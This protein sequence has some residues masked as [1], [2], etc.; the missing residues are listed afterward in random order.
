MYHQCCNNLF[1]IR[2]SER[3]FVTS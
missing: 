2:C 3:T 1:F